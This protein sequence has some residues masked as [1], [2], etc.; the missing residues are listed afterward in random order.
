MKLL[1][2]KV[3]ENNL[4]LATQFATQSVYQIFLC[5]GSAHSRLLS[6]SFKNYLGKTTV[7]VSDNHTRQISV[8]QRQ[9]QKSKT[10]HV[11]W[12]K[13]A[14][15]SIRNRNYILIQVRYIHLKTTLAFF[16]FLN[17]TT[18]NHNAK[19]T[20]ASPSVILSYL[21]RLYT[22]CAVSVKDFK[23]IISFI[24]NNKYLKSCRSLLYCQKII[25]KLCF[26]NKQ[27]NIYK[28]YFQLIKSWMRMM[29]KMQCC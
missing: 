19:D 13:V 11:W 3:K 2:G 4:S 12:G 21:I 20:S 28:L 7:F 22:L 15:W 29:G 8:L 5:L 24:I 16:P 10:C 18:K 14:C 1:D 25:P 17:R 27:H 9:K 6:L 23:E 26:C